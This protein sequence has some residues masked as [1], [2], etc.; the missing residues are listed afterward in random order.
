MRIGHGQIKARAQ[1]VAA[2]ASRKDRYLQ[3]RVRRPN[4]QFPAVTGD[5]GRSLLF[6]GG[7]GEGSVTSHNPQ[8]TIHV[9]VRGEGAFICIKDYPGPG[10]LPVG[11]GG[12]ELSFY[13]A[14]LTV[15]WLAGWR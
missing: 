5:C 3:G 4:K 7:S 15:P 12:R 1:D 14:G 9:E 13:P 6:C 2:D 10:G 8:V 11:T